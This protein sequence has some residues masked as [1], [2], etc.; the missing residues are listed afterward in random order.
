MKLLHLFLPL[1]KH[2]SRPHGQG[3]QQDAAEPKRES[4]PDGYGEAF[5]MY[6]TPRTV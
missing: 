4:I 3:H 2:D 5:I 6:P 1:E